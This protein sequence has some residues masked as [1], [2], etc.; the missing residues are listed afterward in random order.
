MRNLRKLT[1]VVV[2][3]ALVL[4]SMATAFAASTTYEFEAQA[5]VLKDLGIWTGNASGD[6]M[7]GK[8]LTR[9]EGAVLVLKTVL[10]K[11]EAD[12]EAA[13]VTS[14]DTFADAA[15]VPSWAEG[16]IALAVEA[17]VV[18]GSDNKLNAAA[19]LLGKDLASMFMN[20]LG[21][22]AEN[23]Y[24]KAVE[25]LAAKATITSISA[26]IP[27]DD[28]LLRDAATAIVTDALTAK[29]KDAKET[30][31]VKYVG[32]DASLKAIAEKAGLI[33]VAAA[34]LVVESIK[35]L[36][37]KQIEVKFNKDMDKDSAETES[38]YSVKDKGGST[39]TTLGSSSAAL[40]DS[41]TVVISLNNAITDKLTNSSTAKVKVKKDI[42]AADGKKLAAD[43]EL[44]V[45]VQDGILPTVSKIEATGEKN[46]RLTFSEPVYG[47]DSG[48]YGS[49]GNF[50][51]N[52]VVK[53]GTYTYFVQNVTISGITA[54][55][56]LGTSLIEGPVVVTVNKDGSTATAVQDYAGYKIFKGDSTFNYVKDTSVAVVSIS[57]A[58]PNEV[59]VKFSKP[60]KAADLRLFHSVK[61]VAAYCANIATTSNNYLDE[62]TF[63][64]PNAVPPGDISFFLVN[65]S[66]AGNELVDGYGVKV[67]DQT[68]TAKVV[69]DIAGPV[70]S[71]TELD[72][73][74]AF[75]ITFDEALT[76]TSIDK[77]NITFKSV[78]DGKDVFYNLSNDTARKVLTLTVPGNL[79]D[80]TQY[81]VVVKNA[82]DMYGNK[83]AAE[84]T[85]TFTTGDNTAPSVKNDDCYAVGSDGKI[86]VFFSE[87]M[88]EAQMLDKNNYAVATDHSI[89]VLAS[90]GTDDT[91][92]KLSEKAVVI[93][94]ASTVNQPLVKIA[95]IMDLA[96][97]R[98]GNSLDSILIKNNLYN[99]H[100]GSTYI[101]SESVLIESA[102]LIAKNKVKVTFDKEL[103]SF[104]N[105]DITFTTDGSVFD[106][107][108]VQMVESSVKNTDGKTEVV[109]VLDKDMATDAKY[110]NTN[111]TCGSVTTTN[112]ISASGTKLL[113]NQQK[114]VLDL[115]APEVVKTTING[116]DVPSVIFTTTA[117]LNIS[118]KVVKGDTLQ[119]RITLSEA[120]KSSTL[121]TLTFKVEGYTVTVVNNTVDPKVVYIEA[122]A[123][124][125]VTPYTTVKQVYD[126]TDASPD[127]NVLASGTVWSVT[128]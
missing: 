122:T 15:K 97:K 2:A 113:P 88:N 91:V 45:A 92:T 25:L 49:S 19:P 13:D 74:V 3:I 121:S 106:A 36:N 89:S 94:M 108:K 31:I 79:A 81:Q 117:A 14:I 28:A 102:K 115:V 119:I 124:D 43:K 33:A 71:S 123:N 69:A 11:T 22:S 90:L 118:G 10:G 93:D 52:F 125:D 21:F 27:A 101:K 9:A 75:K 72:T 59:K 1:A 100:S 109:L 116:T 48:S 68:L 103:S 26:K 62:I 58:K 85:F 60:V 105:T 4:T 50:K 76:S 39:E 104:A 32:S 18:K 44:E 8:E 120:I 70:V 41:K 114:Q 128:K 47:G 98:L 110:N 24:A 54:T 78:T 38:F 107:I 73:N 46:I 12:M 84:A 64:F 40:V 86:Y 20:A 29:A 82:E 67:P 16:W 42:K 37:A 5:T 87:P 127:A 111:I 51:D 77:K 7:L 35:A 126:I 99:N 112:S 56:D 34:D 57:D 66:T 80:N 95:P 63:T 6:L 96:G 83:M 17:G 61:G 65:S 53:S 30:V 55:L 23:D